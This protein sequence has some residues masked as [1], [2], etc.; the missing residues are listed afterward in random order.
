MTRHEQLVDAVRRWPADERAWW[1]RLADTNPAEAL[2]VAELALE[3]DAIP[4]DRVPLDDG[5]ADIRRTPPVPPFTRRE[6]PQE[7]RDLLARLGTNRQ[8]VPA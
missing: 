2:I 3:L 7:A 8:E 4:V 1:R 5:Q 6:L